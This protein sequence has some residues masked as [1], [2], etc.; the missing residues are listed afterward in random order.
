VDSGRTGNKQ[1]GTE[2]GK[3]FGMVIASPDERRN[4]N[5]RRVKYST[6]VLLLEVRETIARQNWSVIKFSTISI[7]YPVTTLYVEMPGG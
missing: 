4:Q 6:N 1:R 5:N 7:T 3:G 2:D